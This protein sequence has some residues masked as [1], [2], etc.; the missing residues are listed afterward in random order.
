MA[1]PFLHPMR[2]PDTLV[3]EQST[4]ELKIRGRWCAHRGEPGH[5]VP[6]A[7]VGADLQ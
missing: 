1:Q 2:H 5:W 7:Y 4:G 3:M 6:G